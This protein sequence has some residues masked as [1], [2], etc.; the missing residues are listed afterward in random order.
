MT[1]GKASRVPLFVAGAG[2]L[3]VAVAGGLAT[4]IGPW[5]F[6][7][8][9]PAWQPPDWLFGPVW[10]LIFILCAIAAAR[11]WIGA[12][13]LQRKK[14][15]LLLFATNG[16]LNIGWSVLFFTLR[17]PDWALA[18]IPLLWLSIVLIMYLCGQDAPVVRWLLV[19]YLLWVTFAATLNLAVVQLNHPFA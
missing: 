15:V 17:R 8:R 4:R 18:E 2:A 9:K 3:I 1:Q 12:R 16:L 6:S 5:Y 13:S 7:L 11:A 10:T 19:P 14:I